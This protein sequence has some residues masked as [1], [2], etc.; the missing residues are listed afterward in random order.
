MGPKLPLLVIVGIFIIGVCWIRRSF[1]V[2][3]IYVRMLVGIIYSVA[4]A[5]VF[6]KGPGIVIAHRSLDVGVILADQFV[7]I[8]GRKI[9]GIVAQHVSLTAVLVMNRFYSI[10]MNVIYG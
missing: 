8:L 10:R 5:G 9:G 4:I 7:G 1:V 2:G 6:H 3:V